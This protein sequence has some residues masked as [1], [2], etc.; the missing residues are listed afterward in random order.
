MQPRIKNILFSIILLSLIAIG[1]NIS[2]SSPNV[3]Y[4]KETE[5]VNTTN[6]K[7]NNSECFYY[8]QDSG[9]TP[10]NLNNKLWSNE[11][12]LYYN[13]RLN[14]K[15]ISQTNHFCEIRPFNLPLNRPYIPRKSIE[16]LFIS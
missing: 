2:I 14:V 3:K 16:H 10:A 5:L 7:E 11:Y 8:N 4:Y 13:Q 6:T 9:V 12:I 15:I 1:E